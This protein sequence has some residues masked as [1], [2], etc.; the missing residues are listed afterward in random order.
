MVQFRG[1]G[2]SWAICSISALALA[3][4]G[5][6]GGG[7]GSGAT[8]TP[9]PLAASPKSATI[10][11]PAGATVATAATAAVMP[12][13]TGTANVGTLALSITGGL[14]SGA[15][16]YAQNFASNN[17]TLSSTGR[18]VNCSNSTDTLFL[19]TVSGSGALASSG[20]G[21]ANHYDAATG[22]TNLTG[23]YTGTATA[24]SD[25][26]KNVTATYSGTY[27]G[28]ALQPGTV[29]QQAGNMSMS[30]NFGSGTVAGQVTNLTNAS[31]LANA[32]Y[33]LSMNGT[34]SGGNYTGT[35]GYTTTTGAAAGTVSSS[36]LAGG[37]FGAQAAET[38][39]ALAIKGTAPNG[40]VTTTVGAFGGKKN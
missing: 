10:Y 17:C 29:L 9:T 32:G 31:T 2:L 6:G 14:P 8:S 20:Y 23:F 25:L 16:S 33:G 15:T 37:F 39:G 7:G 4:C 18:S 40:T 22:G 5:G 27:Y 38:A 13:G 26:P 3:G 36:T 30:A 12:T 24:L 34:I 35:A 28:Y 11:L 1:V 19:T 21:I